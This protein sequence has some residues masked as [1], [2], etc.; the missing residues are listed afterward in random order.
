MATMTTG[1]VTKT[2]MQIVTRISTAT[3][4]TKVIEYG[5]SKS[6]LLKSDEAC[7]RDKVD[8]NFE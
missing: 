6:K 4:A 3:H 7:K 8:Q 1:Q 2:I 5:I